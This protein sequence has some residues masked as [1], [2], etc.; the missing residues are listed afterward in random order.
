MRV[1]NLEA[2]KCKNKI[3]KYILGCVQN[4]YR[5][6]FKS[7]WHKELFNDVRRNDS[8]NKLR[9]YR[10]FKYHFSTEPYLKTCNNFYFR[11]DI[12]RLRIS[13]HKLQIETGRHLPRKDRLKPEERLCI[14]CKNNEMED[15]FHFLMKC[16]FYNDE[17]S[18]LYKKVSEKYQE[19][20]SLNDANKFK[21]IMG[22]HDQDTIWALGH[23]V[24]TCFKKRSG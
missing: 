18:L 13:S 12:C 11:R 17:R 5:L 16:D 10:S 15:E 8:G 24:S 21:F 1:S 20:D 23:Y 4:T 19:F 6:A 14:Y 22:L 3:L 2:K 7:G 9:C